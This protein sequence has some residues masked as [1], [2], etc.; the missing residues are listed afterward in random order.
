MIYTIE[1]GSNTPIELNK[2]GRI[3]HLKTYSQVDGDDFK[4][5]YVEKNKPNQVTILY[6]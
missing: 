1:K 2:A 6:F 3:A 5:S 4:A